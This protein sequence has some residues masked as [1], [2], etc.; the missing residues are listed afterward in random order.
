M[1]ISHDS[2]V[3]VLSNPVCFSNTTAN[4]SSIMTVPTSMY[5][6]STRCARSEPTVQYG[7]GV[8]GVDD[9]WA[10]RMTTVSV[11]SCNIQHNYNFYP[12]FP[13]IF[14]ITLCPRVIF[15][16]LS[17]KRALIDAPYCCKSHYKIG[18]LVLFRVIQ[19]STFSDEVSDDRNSCQTEIVSALRASCCCCGE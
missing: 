15:H 11:L 18:D 13:L 8:H 19:H 1:D 6:N 12:E 4:K 9:S 5:V 14:T 2:C 7:D 3:R 16:T 17:I 10:T